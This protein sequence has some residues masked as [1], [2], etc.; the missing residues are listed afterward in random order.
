MNNRLIKI[1]MALFTLA[2]L[3]ACK[4]GKEKDLKKSVVKVFTTTQNVDF[5]EPW[6]PGAEA[7][8]QGCGTLVPGN[9]VLTT[10]HLVNKGN[11]IEVQKFGET[12]RY[13]AKVE[14]LGYDQ[15]L[16]LLTVEDKDFFKDAETVEYGELPH[17]GDK[18]KIV[19]GDELSIKEDT[20]SGLDM[21]W[22][23]EGSTFLPALITNGDIDNK[24]NGC[25][26][27]KDGK[28]VGLPFDSWHKVE[29]TGSI[30]PVNMVRR[31]LRA[32]EDGRVYGGMPDLG[33]YAQELE[34]PA[35]R[36]YYGLTGEQTGI[37]VTKVLEEG[38]SVGLLREGDV[39]TAVDGHAIDNDGYITLDKKSERI[40]ADYLIAFYLPG[41]QISLDL[42][43]DGKPMKLK[44]PLK[45]LPTLVP[46][47]ADNRHPTYFVYAGLVFVPLTYN[48][49]QSAD[50]KNMKPSLKDLYNHGVI[51][52]ERK[53]VVLISHVLP[54]DI[55]TGYDKASNLIVDK[56][57]GRPIKEMK[58]LVA[59]FAA[60]Q[61]NYQV[62]EMDEHAWYGS[63]IVLD[64]KKAPRA[65]E[66]IMA[67]FKI[68][69]DRSQDLK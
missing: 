57:N 47:R 65:N 20:I 21:V 30:I 11:Y 5:Y 60:P 1:L 52:A 28:F 64:A 34:N 50:W 22:T 41:E 48:Y 46:Y 24:V 39:L 43:R 68:P 23:W 40:Q 32:T 9:R 25:P 53:Q 2:F 42:L 67:L 33:V 54:H 36:D 59:A 58:D 49:M 66:E 35:I 14:K 63:R 61:G 4:W 12:K 37:V 51:T 7:H 19:G 31:F 44:V 15:D 8:L 3:P 18:V 45:T 69:A 17:A 27:F 26:V 29:K 13:V 62:I 55:N 6:K 38:A 16:A 10:A 56:V